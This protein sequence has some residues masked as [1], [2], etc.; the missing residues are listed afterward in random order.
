MDIEKV[1]AETP[2]KIITSKFDLN[3]EGP[4]NED[5]KIINIFNLDDQQK[6]VAKNLVKS[7]YRVLVEKMRHELKS[8]HNNNKKIN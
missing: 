3:E 6:I 7:L 5:E 2:Q 8:I 4:S 1:A